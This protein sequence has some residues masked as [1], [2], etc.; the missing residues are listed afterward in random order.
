MPGHSRVVFVVAATALGLLAPRLA[1][2]QEGEGEEGQPPAPVLA[3]PQLVED[4]DPELPE[5]TPDEVVH[6]DDLVVLP[7]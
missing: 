4:V 2:A 1:H 5:G 7:R 6:R 3:A